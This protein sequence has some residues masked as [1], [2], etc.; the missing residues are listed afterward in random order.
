MRNQLHV[1]ELCVMSTVF[2]LLPMPFV[3]CGSGMERV[4]E[5][6]KLES[7]V[8]EVADR[9]IH[10]KPYAEEFGTRV[11]EEILRVESPIL[12]KKYYKR[13]KDMLLNVRFD[14]SRY[15][16]RSRQVDVFCC[17]AGIYAGTVV[18]KEEGIEESL[19][20]RL[21][22]I[23]RLRDELMDKKDLSDDESCCRPGFQ[24]SRKC[25][26]ELVQKKLAKRV[27]LFERLF[28]RFAQDSLSV[29]CRT[30]LSRK[31][32]SITGRNLR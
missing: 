23:E 6:R 8:A 30:I 3:G 24:V 29:Q 9:L 21:Q 18:L 5:E 4:D 16:D 22:I 28:N 15:E 14:A 20:M 25:Y 31:F 17:L 26:L 1:L 12:Q 19:N 32:L 13:L 27:D 2:F 7:L 10:V 11:S